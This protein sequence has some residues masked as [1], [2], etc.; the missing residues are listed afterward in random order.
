MKLV[1]GI[2]LIAILMITFGFGIWIY[3]MLA[4]NYTGYP[5]TAIAANYNK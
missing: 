3:D 2:C 1:N 5:E 4:G